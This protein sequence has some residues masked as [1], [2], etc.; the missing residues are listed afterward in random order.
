QHL[1]GCSTSL[2]IR[3]IQIETTL[4]YH[5]TPHEQLRE[6]RMSVRMWRKGNPFARLMRMPT[7]AVTLVNSVEGPQKKLKIDLPYDL[8]IVL[9]GIYPK[10]TKMLIP[11]D[12]GIPMFITALSTLAK[13]W[14]EPKC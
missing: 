6:Q 3:E 5:I 7:G 11:R 10:D 8:A 13:L 14:K 4:R 12:T 1:K 9:L 2:L